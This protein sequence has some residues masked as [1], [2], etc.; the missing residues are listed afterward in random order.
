MRNR[1]A[2]ILLRATSI[3]F[4]SVAIVLTASSLVAYSRQ[5]NNYPTGMTIGGVAVGGLTPVDA[6]QRLLEVYSSPVE[7]QYVDAIV[8]I[9]PSSVGFKLEMDRMLAAADQARTGNPFWSGFWDYLWNRLP[10]PVDVPLSAVVEEDRLRL[11]LQTEIAP[12]YDQPAIPAQP[13][14]GSPNFT[15]GV[16]GQTLDIDR[17]TRLIADA[18]R[19][20]TNRDV[21]LSFQ[22]G[23]ATRPTIDN[24]TLMLKQVILVSQFDGLVG[25]YM[26]D[27]QTGQE[28]HFAINNKQEVPVTP[29]IAFTAS[30]TIKVPILISYLLNKG[31][32]VDE[33]MNRVLLQVFQK[34]DNA[35]T[36]DVMEKLD[37]DRGPL[38]VTRDMETMGL[39]NTFIGGYFYLNAPNL[40]GNHPT[41]AN[42][43]ADIS[44][45]PDPYTQTTPSDIGM[46]LADI[47]QCAET[48]GGT[49]IATF[50]QRASPEVCKTAIN[51]MVQDKFGSLIQAG[52]PDGTLV[53]H[54]HGFVTDQF[55][56][57]HDISDAGIV[58]TPGGNFVL[59]VYTYHPI[60]NVWDI[61]NPLVVTLTEA[62]YNYFNLPTQ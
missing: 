23:V 37:F 16:P 1:N 32:V 17:A 58:Y 28:I 13:I 45:D 30:S 38:I 26:R 19:S 55:N 7:V 15:P 51:Y 35:A 47:Y 57:T 62:V 10:A 24:L 39:Q 8:H 56:V 40:L 14:P 9:E 11:Y 34:S 60:N 25:L 12:R 27:L 54:K 4:I 22:Q 5:R 18:L 2:N 59:T 43:R 53:A 46:L 20:P 31:A 42:Q 41:P 52:V 29:D 3:I 36:D 33:N 21:I 44:T 50:S 6:S 48:G 49:L 61:T